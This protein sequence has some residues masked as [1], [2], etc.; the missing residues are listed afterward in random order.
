MPLELLKA[1]SRNSDI[2]NSCL[3]ARPTDA[4]LPGAKAEVELDMSLNAAAGFV[5]FTLKALP[6]PA[7]Q[8]ILESMLL[9][10]V[11]EI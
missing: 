8:K 6:I 11:D 4:G 5:V 1:N 7:L 3:T 2:C 9:D 10:E